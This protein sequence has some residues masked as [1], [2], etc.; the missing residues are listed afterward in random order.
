M[1]GTAVSAFSLWTGAFAGN[2]TVTVREHELKQ[3]ACRI[4]VTAAVYAVSAG[5]QFGRCKLAGAA[6]RIDQIVRLVIG[7]A[8]IYE[9]HIAGSRNG[10]TLLEII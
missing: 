2:A 7:Q 1:A 4:D 10:L 6:G 9:M 8:E 5:L 3:P